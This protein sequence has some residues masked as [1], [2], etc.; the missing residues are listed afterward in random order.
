MKYD[1][2]KVDDMTLA[3]LFLVTSG[4]EEGL[5]AR[6]WKGLNLETLDR[7]QAKG[8]IRDPRTKE[9]SLYLTEDGYRRSKELFEWHFSVKQD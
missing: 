3:L 6:A 9:L 8:W 7:L 2:D 4:Y 5:G 1:E